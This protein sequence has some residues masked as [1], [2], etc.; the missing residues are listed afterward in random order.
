MIISAS[1]AAV[2]VFQS[3]QTLA[4]WWC[5]LNRWGW[6][7]GLP[8]PE[9]PDFDE[10]G[11]RGLI[12]DWITAKVGDRLISRVWNKDMP[13][14]VFESFRRGEQRI[15]GSPYYEWTQKRVAERVAAMQTR[16][17][18]VLASEVVLEDILDAEVIDA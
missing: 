17:M 13:D 4:E 3:D 11:R 7:D 15:I 2:L 8:D 9:R 6:P 18:S 5:E 16:E 12:M 1:Q 10:R 14:E